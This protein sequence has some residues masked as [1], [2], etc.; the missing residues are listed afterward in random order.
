MLIRIKLE[1]A[2]ILN[3]DFEWS[4]SGKKKEENSD[5]KKESDAPATAPSK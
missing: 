1:I 2:K 3:L 4:S 5:A